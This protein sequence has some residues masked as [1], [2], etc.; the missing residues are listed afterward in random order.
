MVRNHIFNI[1]WFLFYLFF[2]LKCNFIQ[3]WTVQSPYIEWWCQKPRGKR[4]SHSNFTRSHILVFLHNSL[5]WRPHFTTLNINLLMTPKLL[6]R[7]KPEI[8]LHHA[9]TSA[10]RILYQ[11]H[12]NL[13]CFNRHYRLWK[14]VMSHWSSKP[15]SSS[16]QA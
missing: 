15:L 7:I 13:K 1:I 2:N 12:L 9:I 8:A 5:Y 10:I 11:K 16:I 4:K 3:P 6:V 14:R